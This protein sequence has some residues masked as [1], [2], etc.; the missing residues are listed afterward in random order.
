MSRILPDQPP[1]TPGSGDVWQ[2]MIETL[3]AEGLYPDLVPALLRRV[4]G[5]GDSGG[6]L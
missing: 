4:G 6:P 3:S 5:R 2:H 1:P